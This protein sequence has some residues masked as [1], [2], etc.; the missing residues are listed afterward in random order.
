MN[1]LPNK[2]QVAV[3]GATKWAKGAS[4]AS[5]FSSLSHLENLSHICVRLN[6]V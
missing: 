6:V 4:L 1:P 3:S 5:P 2:I